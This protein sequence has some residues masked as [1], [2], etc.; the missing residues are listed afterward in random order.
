MTLGFPPAAPAIAVL[1]RTMIV[2]VAVSAALHRSAVAQITA[3]WHFSGPA[4]VAVS[5]ADLDESVEWYSDVLGLEVVREAEARDGSARVRLLSGGD[6]TVELIGHS[7]PIGIG[8]EHANERAFRFLGVFKSGLFVE[9]IEAFHETLVSREVQ[10]DARIVEDE[11]LGLRTFVFRDPD[12]NRLQVFE[13]TGR[14]P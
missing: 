1:V 11:V 9:G 5:V 12:G 4:F 3:E 7:D 13:G 8:P 6:V 14:R 2:A 10:V